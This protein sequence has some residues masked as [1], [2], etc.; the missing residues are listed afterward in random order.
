MDNR[1][2]LKPQK[3]ESYGTILPS[4][5]E[6]R[7]ETYSD[8]ELLYDIAQSLRLLIQEMSHPVFVVHDTMDHMEGQ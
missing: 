8:N 7:G 1:E 5:T 2:P 6:I 3:T 4:G